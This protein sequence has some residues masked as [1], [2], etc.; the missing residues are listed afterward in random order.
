MQTCEE[1][2][3]EASL[4]NTPL[5][6]WLRKPRALVSNES[7]LVHVADQRMSYQIDY[8]ENSMPMMGSATMSLM[9]LQTLAGNTAHRIRLV[10]RAGDLPEVA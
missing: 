9:V 2:N 6:R 3:T 7:F 4:L 1:T 10:E 5:V 8:L